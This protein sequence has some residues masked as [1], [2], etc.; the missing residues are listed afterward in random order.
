MT[1]EYNLTFGEGE[2]I[3]AGKLNDLVKFLNE[4]NAKAVKVPS[5]SDIAGDVVAT[6]MTMGVT[7]S[8]KTTFNNADAVPF[9]VDFKPP[10]SNTPFGVMITLQSSNRDVNLVHYI[11]DYDRTGANIYVNRIAGF[12]TVGG[13]ADTR[14]KEWE[15]SA[16]YF[17]IAKP[18][19]S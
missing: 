8:V 12:E 15:I 17:A 14:S 1:V 13:T 2:P 18:T 5:G 6:V 19:I 10:L 3:D 11:K 9:R 4:V 7:P 16:H